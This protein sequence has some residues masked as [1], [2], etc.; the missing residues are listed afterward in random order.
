M[1]GPRNNA[2]RKASSSGAP[3]MNPPNNSASS[4]ASRS[5]RRRNNTGR[6][7]TRNR[8]GYKLST[9]CCQKLRGRKRSLP[10]ETQRLNDLM[11]CQWPGRPGTIDGQLKN[12]ADFPEIEGAVGGNLRIQNLTV[13]RQNPVPS[14]QPNLV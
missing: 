11:D 3:A 5:S 2:G 7:T 12:V 13:D 9:L 1:A 8:S 14:A 10:A 6:P 4:Q